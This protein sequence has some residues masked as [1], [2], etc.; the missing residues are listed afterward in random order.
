MSAGLFGWSISN[1]V[2]L[3]QTARTVFDALK[4]GG[5][6]AEG[7]SRYLALSLSL[8]SLQ[9]ILEHVRKI[10]AKAD[11]SF[12]NALGAQLE[13]SIGSISEFNANLQA[14]YGKKLGEI[15]SVHT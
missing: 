7:L 2:L 12:R 6:A 14:K 11:L 8:A 13:I 1:V 15:N 10:L 4:K 3:A 5:G 9:L